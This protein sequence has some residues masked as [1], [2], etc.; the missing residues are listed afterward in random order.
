MSRC[1]M[2]LKC[3]LRTSDTEVEPYEGGSCGET[4]EQCSSKLTQEVKVE[5]T[6]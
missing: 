2:V 6:E 4:A 5:K 3:A 1:D